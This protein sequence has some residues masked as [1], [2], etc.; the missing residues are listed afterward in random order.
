MRLVLSS[1]TLVALFV[2][3]Q[4]ARP[5]EAVAA[6]KCPYTP[7]AG[8]SERKVI[9]DAARV[10]VEKEL[11]QRVTF[12]A[13]KFTVCRDWAFLEAVPQKPNGQP[14]DWTISSYAGDV[15]E[16]MCGFH[17]HALLTKKGGRWTV[18][19]Y[20]ICATDV[21]YVTWHKDYGAPAE[22]FPVTE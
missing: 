11:G 19:Y 17:V 9:M 12:L 2:T 21:P 5:L 3:L 8:S 10:P 18:R 1:L 16:D 7:A 15:A 13:K 22:L 20:E 4:F 14:I 6:A